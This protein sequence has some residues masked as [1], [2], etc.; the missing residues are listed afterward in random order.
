MKHKL[1]G[2]VAIASLGAALAFAIPADARPFGK[3]GGGGGGGGRSVSHMSAGPMSHSSGPSFSH[4]SGQSF[5]HM[6]SARLNTGNTTRFSARPSSNTFAAN[7]SYGRS[8]TWSGRHHRHRGG[9]FAAGIGLGLAYGAYGYGYG[10]GG[11]DP[12]VYD[13]S[14]GYDYGPSYAYDEGYDDTY[15]AAP[16][17]SGA[18]VQ[19]CMSRFRSYDPA[20]QTYLGTDGLRHSCP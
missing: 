14:Y 15:A 18:S 13:C 7:S 20:S 1:L 19:Y 3:G 11:C 2:T 16:E 9:A 5:S 6:N 4:S 10:Y 8:G 12:Y 17:Y